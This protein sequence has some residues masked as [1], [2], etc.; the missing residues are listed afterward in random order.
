MFRNFCFWF[1]F[2]VFCSPFLFSQ[3]EDLKLAA[4]LFKDGMYAIAREEFLSFIQ[5]NPN[6]E[7]I[8]NA[9]YFAAE[10]LHRQKK[11]ENA[12]REF[13][14]LQKAY[15]ESPFAIDAT[16]RMGSTYYKL[17]KYDQGLKIFESIKDKKPVSYW[18]GE[19][20]YQKKKYETAIE[21]YKKVEVPEY[22]DYAVLAIG[23]SYLEL[24]KYDDAL[25]WFES[26]KQGE[27]ADKAEFMAAKSVYEKGDYEN[28]I[29]RFK[30]IKGKYENEALCL[31]GESL[32]H[33]KRFKKAISFYKLSK[34]PLSMMGLGNAY[35]AL[36]EY[37]NSITAYEK[38]AG[39]PKYEK[40]TYERIGR[41]YYNLKNYDKAINYFGKVGN[42]TSNLMIGHSY[43]EK[44]DYEKAVN[45]Y[46]T[47]YNETKKDE[48]LYRLAVTYYK[49]G[50]QEKAK[51]SI[52]LIGEKTGKINLL[53]AEIA[54]EEKRFGDAIKEYK[55]AL[56]SKEVEKDALLGLSSTYLAKKDYHSAYLVSCEL[57]K[58]YKENK[59]FYHHANCAYL[60]KKYKESIEYYK[61][62]GKA[63]G[64]FKVGDIY[65]EIGEYN[66]GIEGFERF[67]ASYPLHKD[68]GKAKYL[69]GMAYRKLGKFAKSSETFT[70]LCKLYPGENIYDVK[71]LIGDNYYDEANYEGA[72]NAY[73]D[74]LKVFG[75]EYPLKA[76][77]AISGILDSR[78]AKEGIGPALSVAD[79]YI[80]RFKDKEIATHVI[81]KA[82]DMCYNDGDYKRAIKYYD[83]V[84]SPA[85]LYWK[86]NS[87][88]HLGKDEEALKSYKELATQFKNSEFAPKAIYGSGEILYNKK[89]YPL[90]E[91]TLSHLINNYPRYEKIG[92]AKI[93]LARVYIDMGDSL[94]GEDEL[95]RLSVSGYQLSVIMIARLELGNLFLAKGN[96]DGARKEFEEVLDSKVFSLL[97]CARFGLAETYFK[98]EKF[99]QALRNYLKVKHLYGENDF[100]TKALYKAGLSKEKLGD[101][102][103]AKEFYRMVIKRNDDP[104]LVKMAK[105]KLR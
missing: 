80:E 75:A 52:G 34:I 11:Y 54:Y 104:K 53:L 26:I 102:L 96:I 38:L 68:A 35:F 27:L 49:M 64:L 44:R 62:I 76:S 8:P 13:D 23:Y 9:R 86:A 41:C 74:A 77:R 47:L 79:L 33:L 7:L 88:I 92:E 60:D 83:K 10:C 50:E 42:Y 5:E 57:V 70:E 16:L 1:I 94:K 56:K 81:I 37:K 17:S 6:S 101:N 91:K 67:L 21:Y 45:Q 97:P 22:K 89:D 98:E 12:I 46:R 73:R 18:L 99:S 20:Y 105:E 55:V 58:K 87:Y 95:K 63:F 82:G 85:S 93:T 36:R 39:N 19:G 84:K 78:Y 4:G 48:P 65:Y 24:R 28:A 51:E 14:T 30:K 100:I 15:P 66:K 31:I 29:K 32:S 59:T 2:S 40:D 3:S 103:K 25:I 71:C 43:F 72:E 61:K 90:S 69:I